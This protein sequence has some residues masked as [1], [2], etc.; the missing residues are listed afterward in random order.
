MCTATYSFT[1]R[2]EA[3]GQVHYQ[4]TIWGGSTAAGTAHIPAYTR[5]DLVA[6]WKVNKHF[7][8]RFNVNNLTDKV[9]YDTIYRSSQPFAY[10]RRAVS[11]C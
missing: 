4:S 6:R 11:S 5:F 9:Y 10:M 3:G 2:F 7:D 1:K 8:A